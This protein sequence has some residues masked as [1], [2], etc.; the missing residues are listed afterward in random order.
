MPLRDRVLAIL[1]PILSLLILSALLLISVRVFPVY[2]HSSQLADYIRDKAVRMAVEN[3]APVA[4]QAD[5]VEYARGLG[6]PVSAEQVRVTS[7][8]GT[9]SIQLDYRVRVDLEVATW[10]LHFT[11]SVINRAY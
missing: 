9:L 10:N 4:V 6:L 8:L 3:Q 11:P 2:S 1:K 5:V 7:A